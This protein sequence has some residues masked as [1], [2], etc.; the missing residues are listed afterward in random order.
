MYFDEHNFQHGIIIERPRL[1]TRRRRLT[2]WTVG[3]IGVYLW[4][5]VMRPLFLLILWILGA[6]IFQ[7]HMIE[8]GGLFNPRYFGFIC[9]G[10]LGIF[11]IM[12]GWNKYDRIRYG[13]TYKGRSRGIAENG[14]MGAFYNIP[15][16]EVD[17]IKQSQRLSVYFPKNH[18][19]EMVV[20]NDNDSPINGFYNPQD[21]E[22]H[23][24]LISSL[25]NTPRNET[26]PSHDISKVRKTESS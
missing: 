12:I 17:R 5:V 2:E 25:K 19:I 22:E 4:V 16:E 13:G 6:R 11:V 24:R 1:L 10:I 23:F 15:S 20:N 8:L 21:M 7:T 18:T 26:H 9:M 14:Y 3:A